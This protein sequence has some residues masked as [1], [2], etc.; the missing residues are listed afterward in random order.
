MPTLRPCIGEHLC[1]RHRALADAGGN[2]RETWCAARNDP[3]VTR[4]AAHTHPTLNE[5]RVLHTPP[6]LGSGGRGLVNW[7][8]VVRR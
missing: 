5:R 2:R 1:A 8:L 4:S 6:A 3:Q 7:G